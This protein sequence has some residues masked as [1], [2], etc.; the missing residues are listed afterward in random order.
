MCD[1]HPIIQSS[2]SNSF[3]S[4]Q[5]TFQVVAFCHIF[6]KIVAPLLASQPDPPGSLSKAPRTVMIVVPI[7]VVQNWNDE[8]ARW[9]PVGQRLN[10]FCLNDRFK[11]F[12]SR[13]D[14]INNWHIRGGV[15]IIGYE[16][17]RLLVS[18][19]AKVNTMVEETESY[20]DQSARL[21][22]LSLDYM[23]VNPG[24]DLVT[25]ACIDGLSIAKQHA[26]L[27]VYGRFCSPSV[28]RLTVLI[29]RTRDSV[30]QS[31]PHC[32]SQFANMFENPVNNGQCEDSS[33]KDITLMRYRLHVLHIMLRSF[34]QRREHSVLREALPPKIEYV[35]Y[36]KLSKVQQQLYNKLKST[37]KESDGGNGIFY[38]YQNFMK[39]WNHPDILYK[40][41]KEGEGSGLDGKTASSSLSP[42][43]TS[44]PS[45]GSVYDTNCNDMGMSWIGDSLVNYTPGNIDNGSKIRV[46]MAIIEASIAVREKVLV[47]SQSLGTLDVLEQTLQERLA[48]SKYGRENRRW[49]NGVHYYR[50]DGSMSASQREKKINDFNDHNQETVAWVFLVS[51]RAG[52][53]GINLVAANRVV[54]MDV[55]WNPVHSAQAPVH[56]YRLVAANTMEEIIYEREIIKRGLAESVVDETSVLTTV[57]RVDTEDLYA[58]RPEADFDPSAVNLSD[59]ILQNIISTLPELFT[60][61]PIL[62]ESFLLDDPT[63]LN[64]AQ[65]KA[66]KLDYIRTKNHKSDVSVCAMLS[67]PFTPIDHKV[68]K[69]I[70]GEKRARLNNNPSKRFQPIEPPPPKPITLP[71]RS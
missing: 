46:T 9:L 62:H 66:A 18:R 27:L 58:D 26:R 3:I 35:V 34:V 11:T 60:K 28:P 67:R 38:S 54:V 39:I 21:S 56:V 50:L 41:W 30:N 51:T 22:R 42:C 17:F 8:C 59:D 69:E 47:F 31:L 12:D 63:L 40:E 6:L 25:E 55:G 52:G 44:D 5:Q 45:G 4:Y 32:N 53:I 68:N 1:Y 14:L 29:R 33:E 43:Y 37:R 61:E 48:P 36:L 16:M 13:Y 70:L 15:L 65:Q 49:T 2:T 10:V 19:P 24:P 23:L 64:K 20:L 57:S 7:N 71:N